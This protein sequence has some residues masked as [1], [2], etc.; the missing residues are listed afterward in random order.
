MALKS[1]VKNEVKGRN[2]QKAHLH[3]LGDVCMQY[4]NNPAKGFRYIVRKQNTDIRSPHDRTA[5]HGD[6]NI[7][8]PASWAGDKNG[9]EKLKN[10]L[11]GSILQ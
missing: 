6:D 4:E 10:D 2:L 5:G 11:G 7:P 1:E 3:P 9:V 8:R